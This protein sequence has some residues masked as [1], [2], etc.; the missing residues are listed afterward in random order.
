MVGSEGSEGNAGSEGRPIVGRAKMG[1]VMFG[2]SSVGRLGNEGNEGN[3]GKPIVGRA[4][5]G[6]VGSVHLDAITLL[7][8]QRGCGVGS[9]KQ[10]SG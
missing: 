1:S 9:R 4:K 6:R 2:M 5:M 7:R 10:G 3:D 8:F